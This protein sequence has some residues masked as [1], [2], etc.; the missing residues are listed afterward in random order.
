MQFQGHSTNVTVGHDNYAQFFAFKTC[1]WLLRSPIIRWILYW[2]SNIVPGGGAYGHVA[3]RHVIID[4]V[5]IQEIIENHA[6][7]LV[8]LGSGYDSRALRFQSIFEQYNINVFEV[9]L[10]AT[11]YGKKS[12]LAQH[13]IHIPAYLSFVG[14]DFGKDDI[15]Q[16]LQKNGYQTSKQTVF[17]L[18]GVAPYLSAQ[19]V[20][21]IMKLVSQS[22]ATNSLIIWDLLHRCLAYGMNIYPT[23]TMPKYCV[24]NGMMHP[25][26]MMSY[27][28]FGLLK[29]PIYFALD[30][31][32]WDEQSR[33]NNFDDVGEQHDYHHLLAFHEYNGLQTEHIYN[34]YEEQTY[35]EWSASNRTVLTVTKGLATVSARKV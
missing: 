8:I 1:K 2:I 23:S 32:R 29:E 5:V 12:L 10:P 30:W 6:E 18:E 35:F 26:F 7:Q 13:S 31:D 11:Q 9:D 3:A 34:D 14:V 20:S 21:E 16:S 19:N 28:V 27:V 22:A 24:E 4:E 17:I 15:T 25:L 33:R